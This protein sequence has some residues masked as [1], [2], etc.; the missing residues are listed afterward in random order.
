MQEKSGVYTNMDQWIELRRKLCTDGVSLRQLERDTGIHRKTL[1]KIRDHSQPPGYQR[2]QPT[3]ALK[4]GPYLG[5]I[6]AILDADNAGH[7]KQYYTAKKIWEILQSEGFTGGYTIVKDAVRQITKTSQEVFMPLSQKPGDAQMDFGQ[8]AIKFNGIL[9]KIMFFVM[10]MVHSDALFV[11]AFPRECTEAFMEAHVR[12]FDFFGC[13]PNRISYDNTRIAVTK[14]L[15]HHK[16]HYTTAFKQLISH[17]LFKPHFCN[18]RKPNEKGV[19]EG[20][21]KYSRL[22]FM[23]PVPDVSDY[24]DLNRL[25]RDCCKSDLE[26]ILRGKR[27]LSKKQLLAEDCIAAMALP[28]APFDYRKTTSVFAS[29]VSLA[30][31]DTNDYSVPVSSAHHAVTIKASVHF[32]EIYRQDKCIAKHRRSWDREQQIFDPLHYLEL[33]ERKPGSLDHARPLEDWHLPD[34]FNSYRQCLETHREHGTKEYIQILL[35]LRKYSIPQIAEAII[36]ALNCRIYCIDAI[37]Q[38]LLTAEDYAFTTFSLV[39]REHLRR[40]IVKTTDVTAYRSLVLGG[41]HVQRA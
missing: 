13:I 31:Y 22:N 21:V 30:R 11:M 26:R 28:D 24:D 16:R 10:S 18:V 37:Q 23:V 41:G 38:F 15:I 3:L 19:V 20:S 2:S 5:R 8:A 36:K 12:A 9:K 32:I 1:R 25:L 40:I 34:C 33:L 7:K 14:I 29:S 4:I 39:G 27:S 17:Y 35:L 6:Q